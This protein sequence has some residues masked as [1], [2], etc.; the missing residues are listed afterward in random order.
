MKVSVTSHCI[1]THHTN[2]TLVFVL[3]STVCAL[4]LII[5]PA[6][7]FVLASP[8]FTLKNMSAAKI[9]NEL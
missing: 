5:L 6:T 1:V 8:F 3:V 7:K 4:Q 2:G 9:H